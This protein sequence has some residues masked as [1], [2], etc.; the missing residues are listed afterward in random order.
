MSRKPRI[1]IIM[2]ENTQVDGTRYEVSKAHSVAIHQAGGLPFGIPYLADL[3]ETVIDEF[4]GFVSVGGRINFP[5]EWY[6]DGDQSKF[7]VSDRLDIDR[8]LMS[9]FLRRDKPVLGIC[10]GMQMLA[11]PQRMP[12]GV[13]C[14]FASSDIIQHDERGLLHPA[15]IKAGTVLSRI[16]GVAELNVN[17][18]H[19]EAIVHVLDNVVAS[20]F[21]PDGT[22]EAI[23]VPAHRFAL[24]LQWHPEAFATA[25]NP[26]NRIFKAFV[27]LD[28]FKYVNDTLGH[29]VGDH[30]LREVSARLQTH[31]DQRR[32]HRAPGRRRIRHPACGTPAN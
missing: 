17:T 25:D 9:G 20:A 10:N 27:D 15:A 4:D 31:G 30:V 22:I 21:A 11:V 2:D 16:V 18:H 8:A 1:A 3:V 28:R 24:G 26:G 19:R 7:P 12:H 23:E 5:T 32:M 29:G 14:S 6:V 13:G